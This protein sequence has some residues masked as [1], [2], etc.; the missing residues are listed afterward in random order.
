MLDKIKMR[1]IRYDVVKQLEYEDLLKKINTALDCKEKYINDVD[2]FKELQKQAN[3]DMSKISYVD[4]VEQLNNFVEDSNK[5]ESIE[6]LPMLDYIDELFVEDSVDEYSLNT[7]KVEEF[8]NFLLQ[9]FQVEKLQVRML[10]QAQQIFYIG[11]K[12]DIYDVATDKVVIKSKDILKKYNSDDEQDISKL[13]IKYIA[14]LIVS[15]QRKYVMS[16]DF[17]D[18]GFYITMDGEDVFTDEE[19]KVINLDVLNHKDQ[20]L[21]IQDVEVLDETEKN[22]IFDDVTID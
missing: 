6:H 17:D 14:D 8:E 4:I 15:S 19:K 11:N 1:K 16:L 18:D 21:G 5:V 20:I 9:L 13:S 7:D 12:N 2:F 3:L 22:D 10:E